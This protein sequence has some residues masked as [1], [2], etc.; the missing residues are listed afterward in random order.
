VLS[1]GP[2]GLGARA[3]VVPKGGGG[4]VN[5]PFEQVTPDGLIR[6]YGPEVDPPSSSSWLL[7]LTSQ[8]ELT[9]E[10]FDHGTGASPCQE[11]PNTWAFGAAAVSMVR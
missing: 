6:C 4:R 8:N 3:A 9:I 1:L 5:V 2:D 11:D 7:Q 10:W